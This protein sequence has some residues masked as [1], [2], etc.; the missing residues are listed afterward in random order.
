[1]ALLKFTQDHI[2][3]DMEADNAKQV[4]D[5]LAGKLVQQGCVVEDYGCQTYER[6]V[7][8]PTGLPTQPFCI[9]FP[10]ADA[11]GVH[12]SA[13][14]FASLKKSVVFKNM[15]DPDED[16]DVLL[17]FMLANK[18][19]EEQI[20]TLRNLSLLFGQPEKLQDL[21]EQSTPQVATAW[22][23]RELRLS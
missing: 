16:L 10:H 21:R 1:M 23:E 13:L 3:M 14:A 2:V 4:I 19:P 9:A 18:N 22:L 11:A 7:E 6:E 20:Q 17:V 12:E 15:A 5:A 8:H